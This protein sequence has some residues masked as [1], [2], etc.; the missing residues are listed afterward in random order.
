[1]GKNLNQLTEG[2]IR[3]RCSQA[4]FE[5]GQRYYRDGAVQQR[6]RLKDGLESRVSGTQIYRVTVRDTSGG[7]VTA[8]TCPYDWGGDCKHVAATLLAWLHQPQSFRAIA[9]LETALA[10]RSK[11][12]LIGLLSEIC[13][14]YPHLVDEF[15]LAGTAADYDPKTAISTIFY[16]LD[17]P[18]EISEAEG[19][20]RM[21]AVAR[22]A[23]RLAQAG[24]G[25]L[26]RQ[27]YYLLVKYTKEFCEEYGTDEI[28]PDHIPHDFAEAYAKLAL[29]Q[30]EEHTKTIE[31]EVRDMTRGEWA[32]EML[33]IDSALIEVR[34]ALGW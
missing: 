4:S 10:K 32:S 14:V 2:D 18:G 30:L 15:G 5:R 6:L 25:E 28:F 34:E 7:L 23:A 11:E 26:A 21:E 29:E 19:V 27:T 16:A 31:K 24:Q 22:Q 13:A 12:E 3:A 1:M 9:D 20:A 17:P 8:C 33:G